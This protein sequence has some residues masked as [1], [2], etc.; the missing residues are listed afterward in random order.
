VKNGRPVLSAW[1][2][3]FELL[4]N[5]PKSRGSI[6][7]E[8][9]LA[10][11]CKNQAIG[12]LLDLLEYGQPLIGRIVEPQEDARIHEEP[13]WRVSRGT[14]HGPIVHARTG[15]VQDGD[16]FFGLAR[17]LSTRRTMFAAA[18]CSA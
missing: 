3:L 9:R 8:F 5:P 14:R 7:L 15:E 16:Y 18:R 1:L 6:S 12:N 10:L 2:T 4:D 17:W 11:A 13:C